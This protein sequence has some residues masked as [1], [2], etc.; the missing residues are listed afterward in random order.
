MNLAAL[1]ER[2]NQ[3]LQSFKNEVLRAVGTK[4]CEFRLFGSRARG[5]GHEESDLDL[6]VLTT[7]ATRRLK[8]TVWDI[9]N[10]ILLEQEVSI[11]PLVMTEGEF[12]NLLNRERLLAL[13]IQR[14]GIPL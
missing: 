1:S 12:Q 2:E 6:L 13:D 14:E 7:E 10:D 11:S 9:A 5:E 8:E 4:V 3:A